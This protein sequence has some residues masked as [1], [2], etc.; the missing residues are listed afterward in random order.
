MSP[1][2]IGGP[3]LSICLLLT[4]GHLLGLV[5]HRLKQP[6]LI[7]EMLA[8]VLLGPAILGEFAPQFTQQIFGQISTQL[9][10]DLIHG[11]GLTLLMF[12]AGSETRALADKED[13]KTV[14]WLV[15][16]GTPLPFLI[17]LAL[18]ISGYLPLELLSG[19]AGRH[20]ATLL[21]V[22]SAVT[23]T[24]I[25][26][27]SRIF[28]DLGIMHTRFAGIVLS[29]AVIEDT[30][31]WSVLAIA[32]GPTHNSG[33]QHALIT[34]LFM[35]VGLYIVP[36]LLR[37]T[38]RSSWRILLDASPLSY[39]LVVLFCFLG[40]ATLLKVNLI[41]AAFLAGHASAPIHRADKGEATNSAFALLRQVGYA[42]FIPLYFALVGYR[43]VWG[44]EFSVGLTVCFFLGSA[45]L[46]ISSVALAAYLAGQRGV[47]LINLSITANARGGPGIVLA[48]VAL[49]SDLINANFY[50]T[51]IL[52]AIVTS[53]LA[54][55]WLR[56]VLDE[57]WPL[58]LQRPES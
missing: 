55:V 23:V 8:G 30:I 5:M 9:C 53:Q 34:L 44:S 10:L 17:V 31:L 28:Q 25:P 52:T 36:S 6:K 22:A 11:A 58:L 45:A 42:F 43:L 13:R 47:G 14:A 41:F 39:L 57:G 26:V 35:V 51:L 54:G 24:S 16:V 46:S 27:L 48:S 20:Y 15:A 32:T 38:E 7:G 18:G 50:T 37:W 2:E 21:V 3:I 40:V 12:I 29:A 56:F 1:Q 4:L 49:Q 33:E 19:T